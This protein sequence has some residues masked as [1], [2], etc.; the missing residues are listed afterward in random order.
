MNPW[1]YVADLVEWATL[2]GVLHLTLK[3]SRTTTKIRKNTAA[4]QF[5]MEQYAV[6]LI[7]G[8]LATWFLKIRN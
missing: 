8:L 7:L 6:M 4:V 1:L 2:L 3:V 5:R